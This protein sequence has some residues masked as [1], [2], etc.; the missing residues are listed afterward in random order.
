MAQTVLPPL[1]PSV[2]HAQGSIGAAVKP[3]LPIPQPVQSMKSPSMYPAP[4]PQNRLPS[5]SFEQCASHILPRYADI[6]ASLPAP[7]TLTTYGPQAS[8]T[9][10]ALRGP[11][12]PAGMKKYRRFSFCFW[13][14]WS[15]TIFVKV[16]RISPKRG[17]PGHSDY[18]P[19]EP[20]VSKRV[21]TGLTTV[22]SSPRKA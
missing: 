11:L 3:P 15:K 2:V 8:R 13:N 18:G 9:G 12:G 7:R 22:H 21:D 20:R 19:R 4:L 16:P 17:F 14:G 1:L 10:A 5:N 6:R